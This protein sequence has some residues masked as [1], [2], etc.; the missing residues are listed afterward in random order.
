MG[1]TRRDSK[2]RV[3]RTGESQLPDGRYRYSY[4]DNSGKQKSIYSWKLIAT[5]KLPQGK[6][7]C[8]PLRDKEKQLQK[9]LEKGIIVTN[10]TVYELVDSYID[11]KRQ[12]IRPNTVASYNYARSKLKI[13]GFGEKK[14]CSLKVVDAKKW[15]ISLIKNDGLKYG[16]IN[17]IKTIMKSAFYMAM[18][19]EYIYKNPFDFKLSSVIFNDTEAREAL[20]EQQKEDFLDFIRK[21]RVYGK[22]S[23]EITILFE[24]G[25]RISELCAITLN[26][27][28]LKKKTLDINKQIISVRE[29]GSEVLHITKPKTKNG[30]RL[31]PLSDVCV[32]CFKNIIDNRKVKNEPKIDGISGFII[33][34][35]NAH[36]VYS[37]RKWGRIFRD[38]L[39]K[40]RKKVDANFPTVTPHICRH[41]YC[42]IMVMKGVNPKVL[43]YLMGHA[44]ISTTL[45]IYTS[46]QYDN[47]KTE[48]DRLNNA[49]MPN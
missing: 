5:D 49:E 18:E 6:R 24:T 8:E 11:I 22:Y 7:K 31:L 46:V 43:Q 48:L 26:D 34:T 30:K 19:N 14:I 21:D 13:S 12:S 10:I 38:I 40:Y 23:N 17:N 47:V 28:D 42:T 29:N 25:I 36:S 41:T 35:S 33:L 32:E 39:K 3:L 2:N 37:R 16:T 20:T 4:Y 27:V 9:D 1:E 45:Q 44:D 15:M